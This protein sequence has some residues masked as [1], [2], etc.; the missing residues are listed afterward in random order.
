M[1]GSAILGDVRNMWQFFTFIVALIILSALFSYLDILVAHDMAY[2]ILAKMRN[3]AYDKMDEIAPAAMEGRQSGE[4]TSIVLEDIE[5]LENFYAHT[6]S[7]I[8]VGMVLPL[9]ALVLMGVVSPI[10]PLVLLPFIATTI[11]IPFRTSQKANV[12]GTQ[13]RKAFA[14][15]NAHIVDGVQGLKDIISFQWQRFFFKRFAETEKDY[16][17]KQFAYALRSADESR[18]FQLAIGLGG[19]AGQT[20]SAILVL[21]GRMSAAWLVPMFILCATVF[22]P[23]A[24]VLT[25][26]TNFGN[27]FGA[28]K[29]V[30]ELFQMKSTINDD[31]QLT[32]ADVI[33]NGETGIAFENVSFAYPSRDS[34]NP[35]VL[36]GLTF[37]VKQGETVALAGASGGGKTTAARL[38]QRYWDVDDGRITLCGL[39]IRGIQLESLRELVTVVPQEI[40][41]FHMSVGENLRMAKVGA[42]DAEIQEAAALAQADSFIQKLPQGYDTPV[43]ERG[44]RLSGGEKQRLFLAQAFLK[45]API[46]VLD[47]SSANLDAETERLVNDALNRLKQGRATLVIAHRASTLRNADRIV[48]L[49][50]GETEAVGTYDGLLETCPYFRE[51]VGVAYGEQ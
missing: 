7:Q 26:S 17:Q 25:L 42:S 50:G 43:G 19:I 21:S 34:V 20:A 32:A 30:F 46:L 31:G 37:R 2:K 33:G 41:L 5:V 1:V 22:S 38:L 51:L 47:E 11:Y 24:D 45:N 36:A 15:L 18:L 23:L 29:R 16:Q 48:V 44:L 8:T 10:L 40:Y 13:S 27:I 14:D 28:S 9:A 49:R 35:K 6:L 3:A 39:D 12:Q 4:L